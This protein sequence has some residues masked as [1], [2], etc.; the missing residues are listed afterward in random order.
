[1]SES[2]VSYIFIYI[3]IRLCSEDCSSA[4]VEMEGVVEISLTPELCQLQ[5]K[6]FQLSSFAVHAAGMQHKYLGRYTWCFVLAQKRQCRRQESLAGSSGRIPC[7]WCSIKG[8]NLRLLLQLVGYP[9]DLYIN[10]Q[11]LSKNNMRILSGM[12]IVENCSLASFFRLSIMLL[13]W[14]CHSSIYL[15]LIT[16]CMKFSYKVL[17]EVTTMKK[18]SW[19][20][21]PWGNKK[22]QEKWSTYTRENQTR[23]N[24]KPWLIVTLRKH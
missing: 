10:T 21:I 11:L 5:G 14:A 17:R 8:S 13:K 12:E 9:E 7:L 1:M 2:R 15:K 24:K 4:G 23:E 3:R 6:L 16:S 22:T 20:I 19:T 18:I